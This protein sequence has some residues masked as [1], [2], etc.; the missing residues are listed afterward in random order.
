MIKKAHPPAQKI[1]FVESIKA[2]F[3]A[4]ILTTC[5]ACSPLILKLLRSLKSCLLTGLKGL[6]E[7]TRLL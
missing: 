2:C 4:I 3:Q 1:S 5:S 6:I 7:S